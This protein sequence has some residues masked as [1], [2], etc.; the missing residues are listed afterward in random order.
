LFQTQRKTDELDERRLNN[1]EVSWWVGEWRHRSRKL[2]CGVECR[3]PR[4]RPECA[5]EWRAVYYRRQHDT[6]LD[7]TLITV[8]RRTISQPNA[9]TWL[10]LRKHGRQRRHLGGGLGDLRTLPRIY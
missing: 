9:P 7:L 10:I 4:H 1:A 3:L 2:G 8:T 6:F 5:G